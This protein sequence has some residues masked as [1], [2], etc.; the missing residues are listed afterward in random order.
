MT[1]SKANQLR[2]RLRDLI[3]QDQVPLAPGTS[4]C[5]GAI[6]IEKA[7]FQAV[8]VSGLF[9]SF[10][11][12]GMPDAGLIT[13]NEMVDNA[14][15]IARSVNVPVI[16]DADTGFGGA[17]NVAR[18]VREFI[19]AGVAAIHIEDQVLS[20]RC[21]HVAGKMLISL[22]EM[23]G[24]IRAADDARREEDSDFVLIVRTDARGAVGGG[25]DEVRRRA[26]AYAEA[27]ADVLF[28][29]GIPSLEEL[30]LLVKEVPVPWLYNESSPPHGVSPRAPLEVLQE[31][32][33]ALAIYP[34]A[35]M[36]PALRAVWDHL[37]ELRQRGIQAAVDLDTS[38]QGHPTEEVFDIIGYKEIRAMEEKY[39]PE[40]DLERYKQES[41]GMRY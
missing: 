10:T 15:N 28:P 33:V 22:E 41:L 31:I 11:R 1:T 9:S 32:G 20:K 3:Q 37:H 6:L 4:D 39:L 8:Y 38:L 2:R 13:M 25:L 27:G 35:T 36:R 17:I 14:G 30:A 23:A 24:K 7:G 5:L 12:L 16:S 29:D 19:R 26:H 18:T 21:G 34:A 40:A